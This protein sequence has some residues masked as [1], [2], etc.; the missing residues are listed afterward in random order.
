MTSGP[1]VIG[2]M[3]VA[4]AGARDSLTDA[5]N[6]FVRAFD[7]RSGELRWEFDPIPRE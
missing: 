3:V 4:T 7:V 1:L 6:G 5:N 2:D